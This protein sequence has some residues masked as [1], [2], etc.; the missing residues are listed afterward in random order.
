MFSVASSYMETLSRFATKIQEK[1]APDSASPQLVLTF[2]SSSSG[3]SYLLE[4][5]LCAC[6]WQRV[7]THSHGQ[8]CTKPK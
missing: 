5:P 1:K 3:G 8:A 7:H 2:H 4:W 6:V